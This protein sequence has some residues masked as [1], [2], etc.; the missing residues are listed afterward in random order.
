MKK[1]NFYEYV[2]KIKSEKE[3]IYENIPKERAIR[4]RPRDPAEEEILMKLDKM[5]F[6]RLVEEGIIE[7]IGPRR[8]KINAE[9]YK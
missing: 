9:R 3:L 4:K 6:K 1:V 5:R 7:I 8:Y 2:N